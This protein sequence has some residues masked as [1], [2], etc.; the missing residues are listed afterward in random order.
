LSSSVPPTFST[1]IINNTT[2]EI[3]KPAE[4]TGTGTTHYIESYFLGL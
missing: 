4:I 2:N 3:T 1:K